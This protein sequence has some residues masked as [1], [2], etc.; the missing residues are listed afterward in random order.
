MLRWLRQ[1]YQLQFPPDKQPPLHMPI[2]YGPVDLSTTR[3]QGASL[4]QPEPSRGVAVGGAMGRSTAQ[5]SDAAERGEHCCHFCK[6]NASNVNVPVAREWSCGN[7][8]S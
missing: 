6:D 2:A 7:V 3:Q 8:Q 5:Q 1:E 4:S